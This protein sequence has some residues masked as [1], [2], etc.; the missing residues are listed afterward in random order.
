MGSKALTAVLGAVLLSPSIAFATDPSET[1]LVQNLLKA[2]QLREEVIASAGR[3][4]HT[5]TGSEVAMMLFRNDVR[6]WTAL[7]TE[8]PRFLADRLSRERLEALATAYGENPEREWNQ[9][10][11]EIRALAL[12]LMAG[13]SQ[14]RTAASRSACAAGLLSPNIDT[15]REK[16]GKTGTPFKATPEFY[17]KVRPLLQPIDKSCDCFLRNVV[18]TAGKTLDQITREEGAA[19]MVQ[20][21]QSGKCPDP[22]ADHG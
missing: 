20:L 18:E 2:P 11:E 21:I 13:D 1:I 5:P 19:L 7:E 17:E 16:A 6:I 9:S 3:T 22:F 8:L 14:F 4:A 10:G 12:S 15:A